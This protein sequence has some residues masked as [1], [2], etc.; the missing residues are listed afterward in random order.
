MRQAYKSFV[1]TVFSRRFFVIAFVIAIIGLSSL[2][3]PPSRKTSGQTLPNSCPTCAPPQQQ[4]IYAPTIGLAEATGSEIVLNCRSSHV[5]DVT[6]TF[7]TATGQAITGAMFQMQPSEMRFVTVESLIPEAE[8]GQ[9]NWGGMSLSYF[10][11]TLEMWAQ[12]TLH[13]LGGVGSGDVTFSVLNN[14]GTDVQESLWY[15]PSGNS[16]AIIALGNSSNSTIHTTAQF[17]DGTQEVDI[18]PYAT[19]YIRR[20]NSNS[21][22]LTTVGPAG[23]LKATGVVFNVNKKFTSSIRFYETQA[24][25]QPNLYATN[26]KVKNRA[27]HLFLKNTTAANITVEPRFYP[28]EGTGT[29]FELP[30]TSLTPN[31]IIELDL[32]SLITAAGTRTDL[33]TVSVQIINNGAAGSLI[34]ALYSS[35]QTTGITQDIPLRDSGRLRN[36]TGAYPWR[37]DDD[38]SSVVS[39]S[40]VGSQTAEFTVKIYFDGGAY[41]PKKQE[42]AVGETASFDIRKLRDQQIPDERGNVIPTTATIGQFSW[43]IL[44][45]TDGVRLNGRSE[46]ISRSRHVDSSYSCPV[47]CPN[48][49]PMYSVN[50]GVAVYV[51]GF[52]YNGVN[53]E[54]YDCYSRQV[55]ID[56]LIPGLHIVDQEI[57]TSTMMQSGLMKTEGW[58]VGGTS[59]SSDVYTWYYYWDDGMDC[60]PQQDTAQSQGP[61]DVD[62]RIEIYR[63][64]QNITNSTQTVVV[65]EEVYLTT[66]VVTGGKNIS[67]RE[68][69]VPGTRVANYVVNWTNSTSPT[70]GVLTQLTNDNLSEP[71]LKYY[72]VD[73]GNSRQVQYEVTIDNR[74]YS[75]YTTFNINRPTFNFT[76][77]LGQVA[78]R[79]EDDVW[80]L[81]FGSEDIP[82]ISFIASSFSGPSGNR[83]F[84]QIATPLRRYQRSDGNWCRWTGQGL[85]GGF[86]YDNSINSTEDS[87]SNRLDEGELKSTANDTF[88]MYYMYKPTG[89]NVPAIWVPLKVISWDWSGEAV[90]QGK[91]WVLNS[92]P[93]SRNATQATDTT[94]FPQWNLLIQN[95]S[96]VPEGSGYQ[97]QQH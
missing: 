43:S 48:T 63:N 67:S 71:S 13:G 45:A 40:N 39:I 16:K 38:Y 64:N 59:W 29:P 61:V 27:S 21:V 66:L 62:P 28:M 95:T 53:E 7:Y 60:Y 72:W 36:S 51:D 37:L 46:V 32:T 74:T 81:R 22:K 19:K 17:S 76:R 25:V 80:R 52:I 68:W 6:P 11:G 85:D 58:E 88:K 57:A 84:V 82:G 3:F 31:Q 79:Q 50:G 69:T 86:P 14:R 83:A 91:E 5:M 55:I 12:I 30:Q 47:C 56:G 87:P 90:P 54:W 35:E 89:L 70:S 77:T 24:A 1:Q 10:G 42:L 4:T 93:T 23:S 92:S 75:A 94:D 97:C 78:V 73:G 49:G 26:F 20:Q 2:T 9:H 96:W 41:T 8:R 34:G 18:A 33:E 65:G 15:M 44:R